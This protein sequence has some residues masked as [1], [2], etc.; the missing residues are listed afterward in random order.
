MLVLHI[1]RDF[2]GRNL[3]SPVSESD[4]YFKCVNRME[5]VFLGF[6]PSNCASKDSSGNHRPCWMATQKP[7]WKD[8]TLQMKGRRSGLLGTVFLK[9]CTLSHSE[10]TLEY[11][12]SAA[13][14][15]LRE[16]KVHVYFNS[17][18]PFNFI[19]HYWSGIR[20]SFRMS[21]LKYFKYLPKGFFFHSSL[22]SLDVAL[23]AHMKRT[24]L[25]TSWA[26]SC[27]F[28]GGDGDFSF[29]QGSSARTDRWVDKLKWARNE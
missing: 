5:L 29:C 13:F 17:T 26:Q 22:H 18:F 14:H 11:A 6:K 21:V 2:R 27:I 12:N 23:R 25:R 9:L 8:A 20:V 16:G 7:L 10:P 4:L 1:L 19:K 3:G 28:K 24:R 15:C